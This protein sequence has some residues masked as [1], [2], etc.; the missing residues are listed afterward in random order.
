MVRRERF[1]GR[2]MRSFSLAHGIDESASLAH[3]QDGVLNLKRVKKA[4]T[5]GVRSLVIQ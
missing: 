5:N 3:Y 4:G 1:Y 2:R